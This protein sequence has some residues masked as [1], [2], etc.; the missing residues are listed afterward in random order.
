VQRPGEK[1]NHAL[2]FGGAQGIG[3][4]TILKPAL[5]A[6]GSENVQ[7]ISPKKI[8]KDE[9]NSFARAV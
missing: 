7:T 2:V 8:V 4:D 5:A 1:I 3:K 9:F 6:V